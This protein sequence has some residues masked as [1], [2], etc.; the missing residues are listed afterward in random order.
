MTTDF[1]PEDIQT[2]AR[3]HRAGPTLIDKVLILARIA[4][5][6]QVP[7]AVRVLAMGAIVYFINPVDLWPDV[8]PGGLIDDLM[9]VTGV[10]LQVRGWNEV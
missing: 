9:V 1:T 2:H 4:T 7:V 10:L 5:L 6:K 3:T 8:G